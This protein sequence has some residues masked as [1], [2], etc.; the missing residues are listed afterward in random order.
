MSVDHGPPVHYS[1]IERGTAV[2]GAGGEQVGTVRQMVDNYR[3]HILDGFV[4]EDT[5]GTVRFVDAPE[6]ERTFE[7]AVILTIDAA[8]VSELPP[9]E[10][11]PGVFGANMSTSRLSKLFGGAWRRK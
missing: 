5:A 4:I 8:A 6:V 9:P 1:A 3:E 10:D 7:R 2:Y 11:G